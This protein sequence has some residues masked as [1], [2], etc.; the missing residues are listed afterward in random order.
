MKKQAY[1]MIAMIILVGSIA[2]E[3]RAQNSSHTELRAN[4][5]F[6]F[7]VGDKT[8]P[9]GEYTVRQLNLRSDRAVLQIRRK[10]GSA[11][12]MVQMNFVNGRARESAKLTFHRYSNEYF[13]AEAWV[14]GDA[15]GLGAPKSRAE[16]AAEA[17]TAGLK[18]RSENIALRVR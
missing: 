2:A 17:E 5:P 8:L 9:A 11:S 16:R 12:V 7:N 18:G 15:T 3:A 4:I 14:D 6:Q 10:D 13:F 1:T